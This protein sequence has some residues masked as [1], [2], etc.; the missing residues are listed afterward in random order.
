MK[1]EKLIFE[2]LDSYFGDEVIVTNIRIRHKVEYLIIS[3][4]GG[5]I[6]SFIVS[7]ILDDD[8]K[9]RITLIGRQKVWDMLCGFFPIERREAMGHMKNWFGDKHNLKKVKDIKKFMTW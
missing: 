8:G 7:D 2:F 6:M 1:M 5:P 3:P 4:K 9:E